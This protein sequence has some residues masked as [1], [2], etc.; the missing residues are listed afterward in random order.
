MTKDLEAA[1]DAILRGRRFL[2]ACHVRPDGDTLGCAIALWLALGKL[3][4][5]AWVVSVD[6]APDPWDFIPHVN[7]IL[8]SAQD[9]NPDV[10][11]AVDADGID[12]VGAARAKL[13]SASVIISIDH[14]AG[15]SPFGHVRVYDP[16]AA[17]TAELVVELLDAL[18]VPLDREIATCLMAGLVGDTGAFRFANVTPRTFEIAARLTRERASAYEIARRVYEDRSL[19]ATKVLGHV[20][21]RLRTTPDNRIAWGSVS[22]K[23]FAALGASDAHTDGVVNFIRSVHGAKVGLLFREYPDGT[24]RV[25]LRSNEGFDVARIAAVFSGGG[26]PAAAGCTVE[27][28][29][30]EVE[31]RVVDEVIKWMA[32]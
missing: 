20:L 10:A 11:I 29:L 13:E 7:S 28:G 24:V 5:A 22:L 18:A 12:R 15:T 16:T 9:E 31:K 1:R 25:S 27:G 4:K 3:A 14:H 17:A 19:T 21:A 30:S 6:G 26:H 23:D 8:T 32:S 2:I